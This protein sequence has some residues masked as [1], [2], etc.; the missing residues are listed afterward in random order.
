MSRILRMAKPML[1]AMILVTGLS[2]ATISFD[3]SF[4][5]LSNAPQTINNNFNL[6]LI[7]AGS[8]INFVTV[9][10]LPF[11]TL[12]SSASLTNND[13]Q[14][15]TNATFVLS[16]FGF[17]L[18]VSGLATQEYNGTNR[19]ETLAVGP[20]ATVNFGLEEDQFSGFLGTL[21]SGD[22]F[23][24]GACSYVV[25]KDAIFSLSA[26]NGNATSTVQTVVSG[27]VRF[28]FDYTPADDNGETPIPEPTTA[29]LLG[30]ALLGLGFLRRKK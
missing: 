1:A 3:S 2:A 12:T 9:E 18:A 27:T 11:A 6:G 8:T 21:N 13:L 28:T 24:T 10:L 5:T 20:G 23:D 29:G 26:D 16:Q 15:G 17:T 25:D 7:P 4:S 14:Q 22:C 19:N 30:L